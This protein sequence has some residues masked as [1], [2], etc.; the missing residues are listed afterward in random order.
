VK[1]QIRYRDAEGV[2]HHWTHGFLS[3]ANTERLENYSVAPAGTWVDFEVD[4]TD[5]ENRLKP[6]PQLRGTD[7]YLP[8]LHTLERVTVV[9][10]GWSFAGLADDLSLVASTAVPPAPRLE[11][12]SAL[13]DLAAA[14]ASTDLWLA[15]FANEA[16]RVLSGVDFGDVPDDE[17]GRATLSQAWLDWIRNG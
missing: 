3:H 2:R 1:L 9:G 13:P 7:P 10:C 12:T 8:A 14:V 4:L 6:D 15:R 17:A 11:G 16:L 5:P